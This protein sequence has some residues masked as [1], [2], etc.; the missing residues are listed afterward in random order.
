MNNLLLKDGDETLLPSNSILIESGSLILIAEILGSQSREILYRKVI[1]EFK[2]GDKI[3]R[4]NINKNTLLYIRAL[5]DLRIINHEFETESQLTICEELIISSIIESHQYLYELKNE[6]VKQKPY[7]NLGKFIDLLL[8]SESDYQK[9][10]TKSNKN[11]EKFDSLLLN[12]LESNNNLG[13]EYQLSENLSFESYNQCL[14]FLSR[15]TESFK[16]INQLKFNPKNDDQI[17]YLFN[18]YSIIAREI[19]LNDE[20]FKNDCGDLLLFLENESNSPVAIKSDSNGYLLL[21]PIS[22]KRPFRVYDIADIGLRFNTQAYAIYPSFKEEDLT[23]LGLLR[24]SYGKP[25]RT[26]KYILSGLFFGLIIGFILSIGK[27]IGASRWIFGMGITGLSIGTTLGFLTGGFRIAVFMMFLSTLLG[28]IIPTFNTFI[29][30]YALPE[31]D[32][33]ILIQLSFILIL[34][35]IVRVALEWTQNRFIQIAQ[36]KGSFRTQ[37]AS[38]N[39]L[40][41]LPINFFRKYTF[42]D[43]QLRFFSIDEL[44]LEIQTLLEGGLIR[45]SLTSIYIL[46]MLRISVKL[47]C[48]AFIISLILIIPTVIIGL[49]TRPLERKQQELEG[50]AQSRNLE[51]I[52]SVSKI[53]LSSAE[54]EATRWWTY[55]FRRIINIE[56]ILDA[57]ESVSQILQSIVPNLGYLLLYIVITKLGSEALLDPK[58]SSPNIGQLLGFFSAFATF[59][60][61]MVSLSD[62]IVGAFDL[63]VIFE[64]AKPILQEKPEDDQAL[65]E[66]GELSGNIKIENIRYQYE[67]DTPFVLNNLTL[68]IKA[69]QFVALTGVSGCGKSTIVRILLGFDIVSEGNIYFDGKNLNGLRKDLIRQQIG[70]VSQNSSI[71]AGSIF[72]CIS[73]GR[74]ITLEQ[75]WEVIQMVS[76]SEEINKMPMGIH[77]VIPEG[78]STLSG[79]QRQRLAIARALIGKPKILIFDEATSALDNPTQETITKSLESL[80]VTRIVIAHRLTTIKNADNIFVINNG[81]VVEEGNYQKLIKNKGIF[82]NLVK[83]QIT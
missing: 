60:G 31:R 10:G 20:S 65:F 58:L 51:L 44:R 75:A 56:M 5:S 48:L 8:K 63:P 79:G 30:N 9:L 13:D 7:K 62:L 35:G 77:T 22:S 52:N 16:S 19:E 55:S 29:T 42:G 33:T 50:E 6:N 74:I 32:F 25:N 64:R 70:T 61:A 11:T 27:D 71:F 38:I 66:P 37:I 76:L 15:D 34:S 67:L 43:L 80:N 69:G 45:L 68:S 49:Q 2:V 36:Q 53:K 12:T 18:K 17:K 57:K 4:I 81:M 14:S 3:P 54:Y 83:R 28:L 47:T 26:Q 1:K 72:E 23:S 59:I 46:F 40:L 39:R 21:N 82:T 78:G 41:S 24:F 73:G